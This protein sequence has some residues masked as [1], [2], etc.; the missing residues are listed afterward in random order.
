ME[1]NN[2]SSDS[3]GHKINIQIKKGKPKGIEKELE[4][5]EIKDK[6]EEILK[7]SKVKSVGDIKQDDSRKVTKARKRVVKLERDDEEKPKKDWGKYVLGIG[8][9]V[10]GVIAAAA[11]VYYLVSSVFFGSGELAKRAPEDASLFATIDLGTLFI[12]RNSSAQELLRTVPAFAAAKNGAEKKIGNLLSDANLDYSEVIRVLGN[13]AAVVGLESKNELRLVVMVKAADFKQ[14][15]DLIKKLDGA[16]NFKAEELN[17][18][19]VYETHFVAEVN[20]PLWFYLSDEGVITIS[21]SEKNIEEILNV[22]N[23]KKLSLADNDTY[24]KVAKNF[25]SGSFLKVYLSPRNLENI[26]YLEE[27]SRFSLLRG[28]YNNVP[29]AGLSLKA[30]K[31]GLKIGTYIDQAGAGTEIRFDETS[32]LPREITAAVLG[33]NLSREFKDTKNE[34]RN[35]SPTALQ[36]VEGVEGI[37]KR[38]WGIELESDVL[39]LLKEDYGV[40]LFPELEGQQ[41][42]GLVVKISDVEKSKEMMGKVEKSWQIY[43]AKLHPR[44]EEITLEDGTKAIELLPDVNALSFTDL[45][46]KEVMVRTI[47]HKDVRQSFSYAFLDD[48]LCA[49]TSLDSLKQMIDAGKTGVNLGSDESFQASF[50]SVPTKGNSLYYVNIPAALEALGK[51]FGDSLTMRNLVMTQRVSEDGIVSEGFILVERP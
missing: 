38:D 40:V 50:N 5:E 37:L 44:E 19:T 11:I 3:K 15:E 1:L 47:T 26:K 14:A 31:N 36:I 41:N 6:K 33:Y 48:Q 23:N 12:D 2:R 4:E 39:S 20:S 24:K 21:N 43:Y 7:L 51:S 9:V 45:K 16:Y 13:E 34:L 32:Y 42:I 29:D 49:A 25:L 27:D 46:Y 35:N 22:E 30:E 10:I 17:G 28:F 8:A 18:V